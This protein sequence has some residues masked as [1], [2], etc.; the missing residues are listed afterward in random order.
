MLL[1]ASCSPD[2]EDTVVLPTTGVAAIRPSWAVVE[3]TY[4]RLR[5]DADSDSPIAGHLRAG[6][7]AE[8]RRI[9]LSPYAENGRQIRWIEVSAEG[10][11]GWVLE[12]DL[13]M[14]DS[15]ARARNAAVRLLGN[16]GQGDGQTA[17]DTG[18][19]SARDPDPE[20]AGR[21]R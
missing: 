17:D 3:T 11:R 4:T 9:S 1:V 15:E 13:Q 8:V 12:S 6:D 14:F 18:E 7:V 10:H 2:A 21:V 20:G 16:D 19:S 5:E